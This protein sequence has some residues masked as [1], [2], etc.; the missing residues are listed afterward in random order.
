MN[1]GGPAFPSH[2]DSNK[3]YCWLAKGMTL[4]DWFAS[5]ATDGDIAE[6]L[7]RCNDPSRWSRSEIR[8]AI[9]LEMLS[10]REHMKEQ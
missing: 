2:N 6:F 10:Q 9:A 7:K 3:E 5:T 1:D 8:Y 4:L